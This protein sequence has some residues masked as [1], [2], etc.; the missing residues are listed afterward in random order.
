MH[1]H[2]PVGAG[3][4]AVVV[5]LPRCGPMLSPCVPNL[6]PIPGP[7]MERETPGQRPRPNYGHPQGEGTAVEYLAYLRNLDLPDPK[8]LL[9]HPAKFGELRRTDQQFA[10][11][12][13][14]V[15]AA[16]AD[17]KCW[18]DAFRVCIVA[19]G[20][21]APDVAASAAIR[22]AEAQ[23]DKR[24]AAARARGLRPNPHRRWLVQAPR[25][26]TAHTSPDS[27]NPNAPEAS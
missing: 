6:V 13:A 17:P 23:A 22:L 12:D 20:C 5:D 16:A 19:A 24:E 10:A 14:V 25:H 21:G 4:S 15:A 7:W 8:E 11:L 2:S 3:N 18:R 9:A 26:M 1:A 27:H